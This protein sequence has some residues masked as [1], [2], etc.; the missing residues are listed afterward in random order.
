MS[1]WEKERLAAEAR[2]KAERKKKKAAKSRMAYQRT[3]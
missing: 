2:L 3:I 1:E